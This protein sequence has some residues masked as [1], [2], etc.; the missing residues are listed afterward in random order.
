MLTKLHGLE[1]SPIFFAGVGQSS[2]SILTVSPNHTG[3]TGL[4]FWHCCVDKAD[5]MWNSHSAT[6]FCHCIL[7]VLTEPI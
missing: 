3:L 5:L 1:T 6:T 4:L 2:R 7:A